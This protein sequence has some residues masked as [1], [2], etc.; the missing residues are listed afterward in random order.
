NL[1]YRWWPPPPPN[2]DPP[3][4]EDG[5]PP[6]G[7]NG[8]GDAARPGPRLENP[9]LMWDRAAPPFSIPLKTLRFRLGMFGATCRAPIGSL[10]ARK[11]RNC[12]CAARGAGA[13]RANTPGDGAGRGAMRTGGATRA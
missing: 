6:E 10:G 13:G 3:P 11:V 1:S 5:L 2:R 7:A 12:G 4:P 8:R 9:R